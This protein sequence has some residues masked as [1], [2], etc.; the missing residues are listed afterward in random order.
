MTGG[1]RAISYMLML[2]GVFFSLASAIGIV[3][4]PDV[5]TRLHAGTKALT[6]GA[7][8]ILAGAALQA[9]S[10]QSAAKILL[11]AGFLLAT[12]PVS[13]HAIARACYRHGIRPEPSHVDHYARTVKK[14]RSRWT[15]P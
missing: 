4:F 5:Y 10:W 6:G 14:G 11:I 2:L 15:L 8:F 3:R 7:L 13:T 9:D 1:I 12:N